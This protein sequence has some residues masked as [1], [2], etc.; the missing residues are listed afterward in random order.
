MFDNLQN[1]NSQLVFQEIGKY[2]FEINDIPKI[3][4][5]THSPISKLKFEPKVL[6]TWKLQYIYTLY[7]VFQ[8]T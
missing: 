1:Y 4:E 7:L 2:N 8:N 5:T 3:I 6:E